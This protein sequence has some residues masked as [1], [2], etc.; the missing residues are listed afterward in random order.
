MKTVEKHAHNFD[1]S[2]WPFFELENTAAY[3]TSRALRDGEPILFV[4][5]DHEGDW[6]FLCG[7][8]TESEECMLICLGCA[9]ERDKSVGMLADLPCGWQA[10]RDSADSPWERY[11]VDEEEQDG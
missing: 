11:P 3:T 6:Q 7:D 10:R 2:E 8:V 4:S 9:Y 5:H 1:S